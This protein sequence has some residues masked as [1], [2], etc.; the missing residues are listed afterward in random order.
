[1]TER[2]IRLTHILDAAAA[3]FLFFNVGIAEVDL[4]LATPWDVLVPLALGGAALFFGRL[5]GREQAAGEI[6]VHV[7]DK[8]L[9]QAENDI[10]REQIVTGTGRASE[11]RDSLSTGTDAPPEP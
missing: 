7:Q 8:R 3:L 2:P 5:A 9:L 10:L 1:M 4:G 6:A 11:L